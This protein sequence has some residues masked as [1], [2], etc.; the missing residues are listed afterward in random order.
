MGSIKIVHR[1]ME[2]M[3]AKSSEALAANGKVGIVCPNCGCRM[4]VADT[5]P[6]VGKIRRYRACC[7]CGYRKATFERRLGIWA[8]GSGCGRKVRYN[9]GRGPTA[10]ANHDNLRNSA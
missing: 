7:N 8:A 10:A 2:K 4:R 5:D 1:P 9:D 6:L 3:M